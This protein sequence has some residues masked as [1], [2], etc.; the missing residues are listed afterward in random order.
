MEPQPEPQPSP[1]E[2]VPLLSPWTHWQHFPAP[3]EVPPSEASSHQARLAPSESGPTVEQASEI[4][5]V[6]EGL[7]DLNTNDEAAWWQN[8]S[9]QQ[10]WSSYQW[11]DHS[12]SAE[13]QSTWQR[14][15][16]STRRSQWYGWDRAS[17]RGRHHRSGSRRASSRH[18]R[19]SQSNRRYAGA[20]RRDHAASAASTGWA[21]HAA[22]A[23][24]RGD[25]A[26]AA[27]SPTRPR[28]RGVS[29][30]QRTDVDRMFPAAMQRIPRD[31]TR[32]DRVHE[33]QA[34][35]MQTWMALNRIT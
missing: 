28:S 23:A 26:G 25:A 1:R 29:R 27:F 32:E 14:R 21:P 9:W 15:S 11:Q 34:A 2:H 17:S 4:G 7:R 19:R 6:E 31:P 22:S 10:W 18:Q 24:Q 3:V 16:P 30:E 33:E 20:D 5:T 13:Q 12:A 35:E 8:T